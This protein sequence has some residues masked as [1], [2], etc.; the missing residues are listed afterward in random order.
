MRRLF[1]HISS[2]PFGVLFSLAKIPSR[3]RLAPSCFDLGCSV[4]CPAKVFRLVLQGVSGV[5][6]LEFHSHRLHNY[7][8]YLFDDNTWRIMESFR[9]DRNNYWLQEN[10][11]Y[12]VMIQMTIRLWLANQTWLI[13]DAL[14]H[15]FSDQRWSRPMLGF[16]E[17]FSS[18]IQY[19]WF[20]GDGIMNKSSEKSSRCLNHETTILW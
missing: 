3:M 2:G 9:D 17:T 6:H 4:W 18:D 20:S 13:F 12:H 15:W 10:G 5:I 7:E 11:M 1:W 19:M 16:H 14:L 8:F